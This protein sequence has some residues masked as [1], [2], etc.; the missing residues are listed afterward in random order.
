MKQL[1]IIFL[2]LSFYFSNAQDIQFKIDSVNQRLS[3]LEKEIDSF[4]TIIEYLKLEKL[5]VDLEKYGLPKTN[6]NEEIIKHKAMYLVYSEEHEQAKWVAHII[7]PDIINGTITRTNDFRPDLLV[8]TGSAVEKDYFL[9]YLQADSTFKYDGF[10]YDRGHLAPSADFRWSEVALSES[11]LYSNMSPQKPEFNRKA[12]ADLE[13]WLRYY[14]IENK[15]V[16]L[17]VVTGGVLTDSLAVIDRSINKVSIPK[18]FYKVAIDL[19]NSRGIGFMMPNREIYRPLE[20]FAVPIDSVEAITGIDFYYLLDDDIENEIENSFD[21]VA[22][23]PE[24][25]KGN[26]RPL[27]KDEMPEGAYN[28]SSLFLKVDNGQEVTV[29]GTVVSTHKSGK[30]NIFLNLDKRFPNTTF[31]VTIWKRDIA[32]FSYQPEVYLMNKKICVNGKVT[33]Y[34]GTP[35]MYLKKEKSMIFLT[36]FP[37]N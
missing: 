13:G 7:A 37:K 12:W 14:V 16:Q 34:K 17:Y 6:P 20:Y 26:V 27:E 30:G 19:E 35:T 32:N 8:A 23:Q 9:K 5:R 24:E 4:H 1:L 28:T 25:E 36:N 10:G 11:F 15:N 33:Q 22:W 18:K 29:C 31:S 2:G 21:M 3:F